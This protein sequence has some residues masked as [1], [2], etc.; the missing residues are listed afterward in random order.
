MKNSTSQV[1]LTLL[2]LRGIGPA[3]IF[4]HKELIKSSECSTEGVRFILEQS[5][6]GKY[7]ETEIDKANR[8][9]EEELELAKHFGIEVIDLFSSRYP[10][11]LKVSD[12]K[13]PLL[14]YR[15]AVQL[16]GKLI[17]IIGSRNATSVGTKIAEKLGCFFTTNGYTILSGLATGIDSAATDFENGKRHALGVAPGG[18]AFGQLKTLSKE[19]IEEAEKILHAGGGLISPFP[20]SA[21]QD[22]YKVVEYC[23]LQAALSDALVLVQSTTEGGSRFTLDTFSR[24]NRPLGVVNTFKYDPISKEPYTA[25][26]LLLSKGVNGIAEMCGKS[27]EK[28]NCSIIP[29]N[30]RADYPFFLDKIGKGSSQGDLFY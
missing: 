12:Y 8:T 10:Q 4:K 9:A 29:I 14:Y 2:S 11:N 22:A 7:T 15:G 17:G 23:K 30:G 6:K 18:L 19:Y 21:K 28:V 25:N 3:F 20:P 26:D 13:L 16:S 1:L 27:P 24:L 5:G